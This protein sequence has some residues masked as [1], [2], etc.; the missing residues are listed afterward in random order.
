MAEKLEIGI[1]DRV[2]L[3]ASAVDNNEL[4]QGLFRIS[5]IVE[6]GPKE[7]DESYGIYSDWCGA[8]VVSSRETACTRSRCGLR[9]L[10]TPID[11]TLRSPEKIQDEGIEFKGWL[12]LQP[13]VG[14]MLEMTSYAT[15]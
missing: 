15:R 2:V 1:G 9:I 6:F 4:V 11:Q 8:S 5:G 10:R 3:T 7:L 13:G 12:A 14:A